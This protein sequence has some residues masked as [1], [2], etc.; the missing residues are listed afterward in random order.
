MPDC[1][2]VRLFFFVF[3]L[4]PL[5]PPRTIKKKDRGWKP[6]RIGDDATMPAVSMKPT[7]NDIDAREVHLRYDYP[8]SLSLLSTSLDFP[9]VLPPSLWFDLLSGFSIMIIFFFFLQ[10]LSLS[11]ESLAMNGSYPLIRFAR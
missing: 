9:G 4:P 10:Y 8:L 2:Q 11:L 3:P 7:T 1:Y 5:P 6:N